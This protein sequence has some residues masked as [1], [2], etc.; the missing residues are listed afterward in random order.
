V[1]ERHTQEEDVVASDHYGMRDGEHGYEKNS[2]QG[3]KQD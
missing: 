1:G 3:K 2:I